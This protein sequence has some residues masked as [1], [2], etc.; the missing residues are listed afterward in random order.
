MRPIRLPAAIRVVAALCLPWLLSQCGGGGDTTPKGDGGQAD[1]A[2][3]AASDSTTSDAAPTGDSPAGD[4]GATELDAGAEAAIDASDDSD[5]AADEAGQDDAGQD[6]DDASDAGPSLI[7]CELDAGDGGDGAPT[8][9]GMLAC[10]GGF[11]TDTTKDPH[12]CGACGNECSSTQFCTGVNCEDVILKNICANAT[13]TWSTDRFA[14]DNGA[15]ATMGA[16]LSTGCVPAVTILSADQGSGMAQDP[17][18]ARPITGAGNTFIAGGGYFGQAGVAYMDTQGLTPLIVATDGT[19]SWIRNRRTMA[20]I[21]LAANATDLTS[22][23]DYFVLELSVEPMSGTLCF[24][25]Y[26][27]LAPGTIAAGY[28]VQNSLLPTLST[29]TDAWYA[30]EWTDVDND[31]APS[32]GDTFTLIAHGT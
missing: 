27:F 8:C 16:A 1:A 7:P 13:A 14:A 2:R 11:C 26:G 12:N 18:S 9:V 22:H 28:Y 29:F 6:A 20:D 10:C 24:F 15:G 17:V 31:G 4:D 5:G 19:N 21:A 23:H 32:A 3:E 30:Y 25:G